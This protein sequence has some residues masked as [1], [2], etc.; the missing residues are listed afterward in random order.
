MDLPADFRSASIC[1]N[2]YL[3]VYFPPSSIS[4]LPEDMLYYPT[5]SIL[6]VPLETTAASDTGSHSSLRGRTSLSVRLSSA[7]SSNNAASTSDTLRRLAM[8]ASSVRLY[9]GGAD[10]T[11]L[12]ALVHT[13][14]DG[15]TQLVATAAGVASPLK[16]EKPRNTGAFEWWPRPGSNRRHADFQSAKNPDFMG[17]Q[18]KLVIM[19]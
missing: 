1:W 14:L 3:A 10:A 6:V 19:W 8:T 7:A 9:E 15:M 13:S 2:C 17:L 4:N 18:K 11:N 12:T 16:Q 5:C